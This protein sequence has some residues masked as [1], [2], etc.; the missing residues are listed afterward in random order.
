[1]PDHQLVSV[2]IPAREAAGTLGRALASVLAQDYRPLEIIVVDDASR[3]ETAAMAASF[4]EAAPHLRLI[5]LPRPLGAAGARNAGIAA[6][7][8]EIIAFQDADDEW[9]PGKLSAQI[10]LLRRAPQPV[11]VA[12]G[13]RLIAPDGRDLGPLYDGQI[14]QAGPRAWPGLL[15]RNTI[16]TPSV[17]AW[18]D[19]LLAVGGF[20]TTLPVGEDQ[21][22]WIRLA[23]RGR[24]GYVDAALVRVH[25]TPGSLSGVGEADGCRQQ[26]AITLPMVRRHVAAQRQALSRAERRRILGERWGR[27][28]RAA[29]GYRLYGEGLRLVLQATLLGFE[30]ARNLWFLLSASPPARWLK[31]RLALDRRG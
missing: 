6:A 1:M 19:A 16:A 20:D 31:R 29:Y 21:D 24:L 5:R 15:A 2:V 23:L 14:P 28:G 17:L 25:V 27:L 26:L 22:L 9:L 12:C 11:F 4:Q 7:C 30:P 3:D 13:C 18:R 8:G 10:A